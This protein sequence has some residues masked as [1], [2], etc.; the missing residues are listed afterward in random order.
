[1]SAN[2]GS[3]FISLLVSSTSK[4]S[5]MDV[6]RYFTLLDTSQLGE[7]YT[8]LGFAQFAGTVVTASSAAFFTTSKP[9]N[10]RCYESNNNKLRVV[11]DFTTDCCC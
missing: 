4:V 9:P 10:W 2:D 5:L 3:I 6:D 8:Q 7:K 11:D 1:M